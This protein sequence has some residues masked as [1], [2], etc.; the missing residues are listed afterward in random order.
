[1]N[2]K[3]HPTP[4]HQYI[5]HSY[6]GSHHMD[7]NNTLKFH[8]SFFFSLVKS[9]YGFVSNCILM[10]A[11]GKCNH[12]FVIWHIWN[13]FQPILILIGFESQITFWKMFIIS[14]MQLSYQLTHWVILIYICIKNL[15]IIIS[16]ALRSW[17]GVYWFYLVRLSVCPPVER[18]MSALYPLQNLPDSFHIYT[19][20]Q[21]ILEG[22]SRVK[23]FFKFKN[24]KF[25]QILWIY[26]LDCLVLTWDPI[27]IRQ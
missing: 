3:Q 10:S 21:A 11:G 20:Y 6:P 1:M 7:K 5:P 23:F 27:W 4:D 17:R 13:H 15:G 24:L 26:N 12:S 9:N 25:W 2:K 19:P 14:S 16:P 22:E 18:I 8:V